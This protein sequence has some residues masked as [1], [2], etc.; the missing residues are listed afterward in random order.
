MNDTGLRALAAPLRILLLD[1]DVFMLAVVEDMLRELGQDDI[2]AEASSRRALATLRRVQPQLLVCD[3]SMPEIDGIE[4]MRLAAADGYRGS[5][6]LLSGMDDAVRMAAGRLATA[7]GLR[8]VGIEK[9]PITAAA[10]E[11]AVLAAR[12]LAAAPSGTDIDADAG[13]R[14]Q[15]E[16]GQ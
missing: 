15:T 13:L 9:K 4:F 5:V 6:L 16:A 10:L 8:L 1:D 7:Q 2:T 14:R 12:A 11:Q 3:L